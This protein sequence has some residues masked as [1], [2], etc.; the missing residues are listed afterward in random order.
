MTT[1]TILDNVR[2]RHFWSRT[3]SPTALQLATAALEACRRD[4]LEHKLKAQYHTAMTTMLEKRDTSLQ[5]DILRLSKK[6]KALE[7][8]SDE[9][10]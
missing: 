8:D 3:P 4:H 10:C 1:G 9:P 2:P 7:G 6:S 5:A